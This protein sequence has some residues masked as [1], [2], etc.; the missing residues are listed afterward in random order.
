MMNMGA[1]RSGKYIYIG[2]YGNG[3][4]NKKSVNLLQPRTQLT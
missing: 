2:L 4:E 3:G 1:R